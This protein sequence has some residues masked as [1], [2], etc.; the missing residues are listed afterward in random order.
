MD[1]AVRDGCSRGIIFF[2]SLLCLLAAGVAAH[3]ADEIKLDAD[4]ISFE[5]STGVA[6]AEGN[7]R[8]SNGEM[9]IVAPYVEYDSLNQN[10]RAN[11]SPDSSV[12]LIS[13]GNRIS[14]ERLDYN[15]T[16][17]RGLFTKP[18]G[19]VESF[20]V[21]GDSI[22][23]M[24]LSDL[25]GHKS[26]GEDTAAIW[27]GVVITTCNHTDPH[28]RLEARELTVTP[29]RRVIIRKPKIFLGDT[30]VFSY[31]FDYVVHIVDSS[32]FDRQA[33]FP[34][35]GYES[36]KGAGIG[37]YGP[38]VWDTGSL[39][40]GVTWWSDDI[41]EWEALLNQQVAPG[42]TVFGN[43]ERTN[44]RDRDTS[45]WRPGWGL[46][47]E[48]GGW[49]F[50][51]LWSQRELVTLEKSA[52]V[53][54]RYVLW[55]KPEMSIASPWF[56]DVAWGGRFRC[57]GTW[58]RYED[59]SGAESLPTV[60]RS[61]AGVQVS[62]EFGGDAE[63][64]QPFYN[65]VYWYYNY[66]DADL[67]SQQILDAVLGVR[68]RL[69][70]FEMESSYL[71]RWTWGNSP[72]TWDDYEDREE[73]YQQI[74]ITIPTRSSELWWKLAVRGAYDIPGEKMAEMAYKAIYNQHCLQ[75]E[76]TFRDDMKGSDDWL[77]LKLSINAYPESGVRLVGTE[78]FDPSTAPD[79]LTPVSARR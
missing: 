10:V 77:G 39:N 19:M 58:G 63:R 25:K 44:D 76:L 13:A 74:G 24:P 3:A 60:E 29:G 38:L 47:Y 79:D 51:A 30:Q 6:T 43:L 56:D 2:V 8:I 14:G 27:S 62:G 11:S 66:D 16:T 75:W 72:M 1:N 71:R 28:Y 70:E 15:I 69:G 68:W 65:S 32:R 42:L 31:P 17:R 26:E 18:N 35:L 49:F 4:M 67:D 22:E 37:V 73:V 12:T 59:A 50:E 5:E 34:R 53:D 41:W 9:R 54:S 20:Y 7:V 61:G 21:K 57:F 78:L 23:V 40:L 33:L 52:G 64:F 45:E 55:R 48:L 36:S 46:D